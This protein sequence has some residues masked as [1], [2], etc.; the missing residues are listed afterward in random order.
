M[1]EKNRIDVKS[2][3]KT[4][5]HTLGV[6]WSRYIAILFCIALLSAC[7]SF[8]ETRVSAFHELNEPLEGVTFVLIPSKDQKGSLEF[9]SYAK[10]M[11][12]ELTKRG[13]V[14]APFEQA[15]YAVVASY[16]IDDGKQVASSYP[17]FGQTG[18]GSSY[19]SGTVSS[20]GTMATYSGTTRSSPTYGV[21][22]SGTS[23]DVVFVRYLNMTMMNIAKS[24]GDNIQK[25]YEGKAVSSGS[26]GQM[27]PVMPAMMR[28]LFEDFPGKS[29]ASRTVR[30]PFDK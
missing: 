27:A 26:S 17:I 5:R 8:V 7:S 2:G 19:T 21:V 13:M 22:G 12:A 11:K 3:I 24:S 25:V 10:L 15:R 16:G 6:S 23:T 29:G 1:F 9:Q 28:S 30:Q 4:Q 18:G 14:E 20:Y